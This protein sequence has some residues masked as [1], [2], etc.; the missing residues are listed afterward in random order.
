MTVETPITKVFHWRLNSAMLIR[1]PRW[2]MMNP[3]TTPPSPSS[4][5]AGNRS[6]GK[7]SVR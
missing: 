1:V 2:T 4:D 5:E 3:T 6:S 7:M